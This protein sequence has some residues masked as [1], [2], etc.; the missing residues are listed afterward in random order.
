MCNQKEN[1]MSVFPFNCWVYRKTPRAI[2][3]IEASRPLVSVGGAPELSEIYYD[4]ARCCE[5]V[6]AFYDFLLMGGEPFADWN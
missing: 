2:L 6:I 5:P 4:A 1:E 3:L